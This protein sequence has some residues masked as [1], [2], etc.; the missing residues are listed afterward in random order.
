MTNKITLTALLNSYQI[1]IIYFIVGSI[2]QKVKEI[3]WDIKQD[4]SEFSAFRN[5]LLFLFIYIEQ[6]FLKNT[7]ILVST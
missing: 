1:F 6:K 5:Y 4:E 3:Y 2:Y 7:T